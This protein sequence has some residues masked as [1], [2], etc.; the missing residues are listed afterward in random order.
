M[1]Y[2]ILEYVLLILSVIVHMGDFLILEKF[3]E[4]SY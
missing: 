3:Q 4:I 1:I 2:L